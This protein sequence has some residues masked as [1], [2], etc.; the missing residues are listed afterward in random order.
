MFLRRNNH[1]HL[2]SFHLLVRHLP[3]SESQGD[4]RFVTVLQELREF[5]ELYLVIAFVRSRAKFDFLDVN[6]FLFSFRRLVFLVLLEQVLANP[7]SSASSI[8]AA[9]PMTPA[10][11]P[12]EPITR[13]SVASISS[14]RLTRFVTAIFKSSSIS[15]SYLIM[16][17]S[18]PPQP[19]RERDSNKAARRKQPQKPEF[20]QKNQV[21]F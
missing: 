8:A 15:T 4:F 3:T 17:H 9:M 10:C 20:F 1:D 11:S 19:Q 18:K 5:P 13:T 14:L 6:L 21:L 12:S 7:S 16:A 2:P